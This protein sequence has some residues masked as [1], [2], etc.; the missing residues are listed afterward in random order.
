ME[1]ERKKI[2]LKLEKSTEFLIKNR[3]KPSLQFFGMIG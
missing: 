1:K 3:M 2:F